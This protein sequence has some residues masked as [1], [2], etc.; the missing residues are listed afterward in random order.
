M[1]VLR[2]NLTLWSAEEDESIL[3][4]QEEKEEEEEEE[5]EEEGG[6]EYGKIAAARPR[7]EEVAITVEHFD[8]S[9]FAVAE[10]SFGDDADDDADMFDR[11]ADAPAE[12]DEC[13]EPCEAEPAPDA[14]AAP[15][16]PLP[17]S[18]APA[19]SRASF[20]YSFAK[21]QAPAESTQLASTVQSKRVSVKHK[22]K[23]M[24]DK[25]K[26]MMS[27][28]ADKVEPPAPPRKVALDV[29]RRA[30][31]LLRDEAQYFHFM[32][33]FFFFRV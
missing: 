29:D 20:A 11:R 10:N 24:K 14:C 27:V 16:P 33:S 9:S 7:D 3:E 6:T 13:D 26:P 5:E 12:P 32:P 25:A 28:V 15:P 19:P 4:E 17:S 8:Q 22:K 23:K 21:P 1:Q 30:Y 18:A 2:D 31:G